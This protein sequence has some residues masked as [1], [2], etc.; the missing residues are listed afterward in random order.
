L[1]DYAE[2]RVSAVISATTLSIAGAKYA[3]GQWNNA[4]LVMLDG[5]ARGRAYVVTNTAAPDVLVSALANFSADGVAVNDRFRLA[6]TNYLSYGL[7]CDVKDQNG[8][9]HRVGATNFAAL[10]AADRQPDSFSMSEIRQPGH[11]VLAAESNQR[12][13]GG[14]DWQQYA[15]E[16]YRVDN[17]AIPPL[18]GDP[19]RAVGLWHSD[20]G[21]VLF[22]DGHVALYD[23]DI[24][25][26]DA[27]ITPLWTL[28]GP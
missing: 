11:F 17:P 27:D 23:Q 26:N 6:W 16:N 1:A 13:R 28:P 15:W 21:H 4:S 8:A 20:K 25:A 10:G 5:A 2:A 19:A 12:T 7:N 3:S 9:P 18:S 22:A 14:A 24:N